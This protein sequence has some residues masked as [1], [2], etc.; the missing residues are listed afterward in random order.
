[1]HLQGFGS[2]G[3]KDVSEEVLTVDCNVVEK[4]PV[5]QGAL[6]NGERVIGIFQVP[7]MGGQADGC[8][9]SCECTSNGMGCGLGRLG[10]ELLWGWFC[11]HVSV[12]DG[13]K[14]WEHEKQGKHRNDYISKTVGQHDLKLAQHL[15]KGVS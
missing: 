7:V 11:G 4:E 2:Q 14:T 9:L 6:E 8:S 5:L 13:Q 1:M 12:S 15:A 3:C 10:D